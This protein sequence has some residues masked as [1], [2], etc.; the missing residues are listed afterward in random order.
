LIFQLL[1]QQ[2]IENCSEENPP[3]GRKLKQSNL[4]LKEW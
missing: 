2:N 4:S 1:S 3:L